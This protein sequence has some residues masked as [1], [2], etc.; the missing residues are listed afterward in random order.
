MRV[1]YRAKGLFF[2]YRRRIGRDLLAL[3]RRVASDDGATVPGFR[4]DRE[5][6]VDS[7]KAAIN[8]QPDPAIF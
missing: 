8:R 3:L 7:S 4:A 5:T 1:E 2:E 6:S